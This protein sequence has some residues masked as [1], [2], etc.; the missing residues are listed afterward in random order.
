[1]KKSALTTT[2]SILLIVASVFALIA[3]GFGVKDGLAIKQYKEEDAK[4]AD[5]VGDLEKAIGMLKENEAA[6]LEGV[7][8]Y[9]KGLS[10]Y[11]AGQKAYNE[12]KATLAQGYKDYDEGKATLTDHVRLGQCL[13][14][15]FRISHL[16]QDFLCIIPNSASRF[17]S[18]ACISAK[19]QRRGWHHD[20]CM[21]LIRELHRN[22]I[23]IFYRLPILADF[24]RF[25]HDF[26]GNAVLT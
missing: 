11:A 17:V 6:Y 5:V 15:F 18:A 19:R 25:H 12:G 23:A 24:L 10:D 4:A 3:A 14:F 13:D 1:M 20:R 2:I 21:S 9:A 7:G 22:H 16:F 26:T 8:T